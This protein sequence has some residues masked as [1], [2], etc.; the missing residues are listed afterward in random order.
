M[1]F[2]QC[3]YAFFPCK[4]AFS[5]ENM[6]FYIN[7]TRRKTNANARRCRTS[8]L[9]MVPINFQRNSDIFKKRKFYQLKNRPSSSILCKSI[10][11]LIVNLSITDP[12]CWKQ[13]HMDHICFKISNIITGVNKVHGSYG[14]WRGIKQRSLR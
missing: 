13:S 12:K 9:I 7:K 11:F 6:T 10:K 5:N 4:Y 2:F 1:A 14:K 3:K 8:T